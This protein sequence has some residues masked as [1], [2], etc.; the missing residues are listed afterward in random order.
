MTY[1]PTVPSVG[2]VNSTP[3][4]NTHPTLHNQTGSALSDI[5]SELGSNPK[6]SRPSL[7]DRLDDLDSEL[8][9]NPSGAYASLTNRLSSYE[10]VQTFVASANIS[11]RWTAFNGTSPNQVLT[12]PTGAFAKT[13]SV[14]NISS[15]PVVLSRGGLDTIEG[16]VSFTLFPGE[17]VDMTLIGSNWIIF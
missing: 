3:S 5:I 16:A 2:N 4:K 1:P 9:A 13:V 7:T 11:S 12:L 17:S 15:V 8:G 6:G 10:S 14:R